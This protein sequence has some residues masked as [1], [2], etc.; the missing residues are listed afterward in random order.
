MRQRIRLGL[1]IGLFACLLLAPPGSAQTPSEPQTPGSVDARQLGGADLARKLTAIYDAIPGLENVEVRV[2]LGVVRLSGTVP[3][4]A[5]A[6]AAREVASR[7]Q[8]VVQVVGE[9]EIQ[10]EVAERVAPM[11]ERLNELLRRVRRNLPLMAVAFGIVVLFSLLASLVRR[12]NR[13][14]SGFSGNVLLRGLLAQGAAVIIFLLGLFLALDVLDLG[15]LVGALAG[16]AGVIGIALGFATRDMV[17]NYLASILLSAHSPFSV[18]DWVDV[19]EHSGSVVRMTSRELVL[20]TL[21]GNHVRIPNAQVFKSVIV[22]YT[23]NP[24]RAFTFDVGLGVEEELEQ[25]RDVGLAALKAMPGVLED[26]PPVMRTMALGDSSV[27]VRFRGWVDQRQSDFL[28][29]QSEAIRIVKVAF[30][31]QDIDMPAPIHTVNLRNITDAPGKPGKPDKPAEPGAAV[32]VQAEAARADVG[33]ET[34]L[35]EQIAEDQQ[36]AADERNLLEEGR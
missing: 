25:A 1:A 22:N 19:D 34:H 3:G 2:E 20:M 24:L 7:F 29:V 5:Q 32:S 26:P 9:P 36:K 8:G 11:L 10:A 14:F 15:G 31:E 16:A 12:A 33:R 27:I 4:E 18:R 23:R 21:E 35:D 30:D 6:T 13:L 17:E 28:K